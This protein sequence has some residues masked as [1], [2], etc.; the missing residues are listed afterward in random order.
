[1]PE[2][3]GRTAQGC[4]KLNET[5]V[6]KPEITAPGSEFGRSVQSFNFALVHDVWYTLRI[7]LSSFVLCQ[8]SSLLLFVLVFLSI[9]LV[10]RF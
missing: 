7:L 10:D 8:H 2:A 9:S 1:M 4:G 5:T 6:G 3:I